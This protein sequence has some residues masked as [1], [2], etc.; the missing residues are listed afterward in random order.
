MYTQRDQ[1]QLYCIFM[2]AIAGIEAVIYTVK[3]KKDVLS[4]FQLTLIVALFLIVSVGYNATVSRSIT[5]AKWF[6]QG[7]V[8]IM[9]GEI[10]QVGVSFYLFFADSNE[11]ELIKKLWSYELLNLVAMG[12]GVHLGRKLYGF[13]TSGAIL[14]TGSAVSPDLVLRAEEAT[15]A[16]TNAGLGA[17]LQAYRSTDASQRDTELSAAGTFRRLAPESSK[18]MLLGGP[19]SPMRS[20]VVAE[21]KAPDLDSSILETDTVGTSAVAT[22]LLV[23][24]S[25]VEL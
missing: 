17:T 19:A 10:V 2:I 6:Y 24:S 20:T 12:V 22:P 21:F 14:T 11:E 8:V 9:I 4:V 16:T 15:G 1:L 25:P 18:Q 13:L 3:I 5:R 23:A 7:L